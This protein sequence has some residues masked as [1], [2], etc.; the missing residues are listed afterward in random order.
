ME[1][2]EALMNSNNVN[3]LIIINIII[4]DKQTKFITEVLNV[5]RIKEKPSKLVRSK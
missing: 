4:N 5:K 2:Y 3:T 1:I